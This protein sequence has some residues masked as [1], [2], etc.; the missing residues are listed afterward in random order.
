[1]IQFV[2][3]FIIL[4]LDYEGWQDRWFLAQFLLSCGF[5][6]ILILA[7]VLACANIIH[8]MRSKILVIS[9]K[10]Y[11]QVVC[12]QFNSALTTT[13]I[14]CLKNILITYLGMMIGGDYQYS[15][16]NFIGLNISV[17][18]SLVYTKGILRR[19]LL[20]LFS[21]TFPLCSNLQYEKIFATT[22]NYCRRRKDVKNS[23]L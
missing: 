11:V 9:F 10:I 13:I 22:D 21:S 8:N 4:S 5:G 23:L 2:K 15:I 20:L 17:F 7:T 6:F 16:L 3:T 14:G 18:G 12:T 19:D 1:M